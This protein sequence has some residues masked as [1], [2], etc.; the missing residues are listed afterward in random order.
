MQIKFCQ[1]DAPL[2]DVKAR[3]EVQA[4]LLLFLDVF[5]LA[6]EVMETLGFYVAAF[7]SVLS[8]T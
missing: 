4:I 2:G 8:P 5:L 7:Q 1:V 6:P 3:N